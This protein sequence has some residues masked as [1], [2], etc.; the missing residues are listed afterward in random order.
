MKYSTIYSNDNKIEIFNS[1]LGQETIKVN[2]VIV[3]SKFSITGTEHHFKLIEQNEEESECK[4]VTGFGI[5]G[6]VI[7]FYKNGKPIIESPKNGCFGF[8]IIVMVVV[9]VI[10]ILENLIGL[11][12]N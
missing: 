12:A 4:I 10:E 6:V 11:F 1:L 9:F 7:D 5:N 3:S 2:G 8:I